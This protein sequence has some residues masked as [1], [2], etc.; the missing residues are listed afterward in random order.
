MT[1]LRITPD[2]IICNS[3]ISACQ[4]EGHWELALAVLNGMTRL[5]ITPDVISCS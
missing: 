2:L 3:A 1:D 5:W 4:K